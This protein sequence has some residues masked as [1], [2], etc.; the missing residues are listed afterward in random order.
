MPQRFARATSV[1]WLDFNRWGCLW[2]YF[3]RTLEPA[4]KRNGVLPGSVERLSWKMVKFIMF[5]Q[6]RNRGKYQRLL[7][8]FGIP[9]IRLANMQALQA[10]YRAWDMV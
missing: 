5:F 3:C 9:L 1:I 10:C 6:P 7:E 2:R 4:S 8:D